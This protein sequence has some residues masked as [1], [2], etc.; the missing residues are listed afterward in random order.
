MEKY[1]TVEFKEIVEF[2][3]ST[4]LGQIQNEYEVPRV[5]FLF[6]KDG[7]DLIED[8]K[9]NPFELE[10]YWTPSINEKDMQ[11][12]NSRDENCF[13]IKVHNAKL[14]FSLLTDLINES[15][16]LDEVYHHRSSARSRAQVLLRRIWL[17]MDINDFDNV[18]SFL[19]NQLMFLKDMTFDTPQAVDLCDYDGI[20]VS[21]RTECLSNHYENTRQALFKLSDGE[22]YHDLANVLYDIKE[23]NGE[24]V[25][26]IGAIQKPMNSSRNKKIERK[27]YKINSLSPNHISNIHP[28]LSV[29]LLLF[30][31]MLESKGITH[32]KVPLYRVLLNDYHIL[33]SKSIEDNFKFNWNDDILKYMDFLKERGV[34][35]E[36][37]SLSR[38]YNYDKYWY[39]HVVGKSEQISQNKTDSLVNTFM[40]MCD[41]GRCEFNALPLEDT[42]YLDITLNHDKKMER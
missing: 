28:N 2:F 7:L 23:E 36:Y 18:E 4:T 26:Y 17:R 40:F 41:I 27:L 1:D 20:N 25:C 21:F 12:V 30:M 35:F 29:S 32:I 14:F 42:L 9:E 6:G 37:N 15:L 5:D 34:T 11:C 39:D 24:K 38:K 16:K 22:N 8:V 13:L 31:N 19:F 3:V 33:L 10:G